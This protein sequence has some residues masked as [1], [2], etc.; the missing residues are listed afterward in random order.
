M[1]SPIALK[2]YAPREGAV[3]ASAHAETSFIVGAAIDH[4]GLERLLVTRDAELR[5]ALRLGRQAPQSWRRVGPADSDCG[6]DAPSVPA[7]AAGVAPD[8]GRR[9]GG[10]SFAATS[11]RLIG[12]LRRRSASHGAP[13][14]KRWTVD[15]P[16][17]LDSLSRRD[18]RTCV[19]RTQVAA[20]R[21]AEL[22]SRVENRRRGAGAVRCVLVECGGRLRNGD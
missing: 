7:P 10:S 14:A 17:A 21:A 11:E 19:T 2:A 5:V 8:D 9:R 20:V 3:A 4:G 12:A 18:E 15:A 13:R 6:L 1:I 22:A 16:S